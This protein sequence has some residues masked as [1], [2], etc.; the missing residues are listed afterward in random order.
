M[1]DDLVQN[2]DTYRPGPC[3]S[4]GGPVDVLGFE[5]DRREAGLV[6]YVPRRKCRNGECRTNAG[7]MSDP[8]P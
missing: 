7:R 1:S 5:E 2:R 6:G 3:R 8:R 4:C